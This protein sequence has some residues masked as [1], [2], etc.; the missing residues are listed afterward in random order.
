MERISA[1]DEAT[2]Q[3]RQHKKMIKA[4]D[5]LGIAHRPI[6]RNVDVE[7]RGPARVRLLPGRLPEGVQAVDDEDATSRTPPTRAPR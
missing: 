7:L 3:N 4:L 5:E 1:T 2:T 6:V